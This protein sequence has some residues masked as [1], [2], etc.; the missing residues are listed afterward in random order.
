M[1]VYR[2]FLTSEYQDR[3]EFLASRI[4]GAHAAI[5]DLCRVCT[6]EEERAYQGLLE[7]AWEKGYSSAEIGTDKLTC[8][9]ES[10]KVW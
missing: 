2:V 5:L 1:Q 7:E 8:I 9:T 6:V 4:E 3:Q 10:V